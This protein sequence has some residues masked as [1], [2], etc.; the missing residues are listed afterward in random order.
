M[1]SATAHFQ[2]RAST[3]ICS[4]R[5]AESVSIC[6][7]HVLMASAP[8]SNAY[9]QQA[10]HVP[11]RPGRTEAIRRRVG[12]PTGPATDIMREAGAHRNRIRVEEGLSGGGA[13]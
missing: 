10:H 8:A 1:R 4:A 3:P 9:L 6:A 7:Q 12:C 11:S 13:A 2:R 5:T